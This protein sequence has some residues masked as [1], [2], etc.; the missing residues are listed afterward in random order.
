MKIIGS[1]SLR[2]G[3][4]ALA[5]SWRS[6]ARLKERIRDAPLEKSRAV[7]LGP[8]RFRHLAEERVYALVIISLQLYIDLINLTEPL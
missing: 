3:C 6:Y 8:W 1:P 4:C 5:G 2:S 7:V